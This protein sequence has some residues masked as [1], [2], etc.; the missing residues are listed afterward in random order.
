MYVRQAKR[1]SA[2]QRNMLIH[3]FTDDQAHSKITAVPLVAAM[4]AFAARR[5]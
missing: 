5:Q 4:F 3:L 1:E 2:Q